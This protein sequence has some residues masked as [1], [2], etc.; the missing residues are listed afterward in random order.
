MTANETQIKRKRG[1]QEGNR[2]ACKHGFYSGTLSPA[3][4]CELW[5]ITNQEGVDPELALIRVKLQ[6]SLE[7]DPGNRRV[8]REASRQVVRWYSENYG[9]DATTRSYLKTI[10][11]DLL[12]TASM[13][14]SAALQ[15]PQKQMADDETN[16]TY[17]DNLIGHPRYGKEHLNL[18]KTRDSCE[19]NP[20]Q[21]RSV[22][23]PP[24]TTRKSRWQTDETNRGTLSTESARGNRLTCEKEA[25]NSWETSPSYKTN[26]PSFPHSLAPVTGTQVL[27]VYLKPNAGREVLA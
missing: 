11:A 13:R 27:S 7:R 12:E 22:T 6:S 18:G 15:S 8:I 4:T 26:H 16:R 20:S 23:A 3:E 1:G 24:L 10:V 2:N 14:P 25:S 17:F 5:T 19:T 21:L 9:L